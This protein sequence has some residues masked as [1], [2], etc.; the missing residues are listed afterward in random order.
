M[1]FATIV[2]LKGGY[3]MAIADLDLRFGSI[4]V[5]KGFITSEQLVDAL[6]IQVTE[7]VENNKHRLIGEILLERGSMTV[8]QIDD[9]LKDMM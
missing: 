2:F 7:N 5:Q 1:F 6:A 4:A 9:V 8:A 3:S